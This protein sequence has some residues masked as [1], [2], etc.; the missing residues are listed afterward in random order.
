LPGFLNACERVYAAHQ[1]FAATLRP[2][3]HLTALGDRMNDNAKPALLFPGQGSQSVGMGQEL[4]DSFPTA[5]ATFDEADDALGFHLKHVIFE[6]PADTLQLTEYTQPA[7][8]AVSIAAFRVLSEQLPEL[9]PCFA[10]GHSLG[11]YAA[12]VAAGTI[13]FAEAIRT[14]RD[15]GRFMQQAVPAGQGAMAAILGLSAEVVNDLCAQACDEMTALPPLDAT[16]SESEESR[17][18][19]AHGVVSPANLNTPEQV[20]ISGSVAAV[21][22]AV[23]LCKAAGARKTIMLKVS[24]PFHCA[25]MQPAQEQLACALEAVTFNDPAYPVACNVDARLVTRAA[26][27]RDCLIR[28]VTGPVRWVECLDLLTGH[29]VTHLIEVGPGK[30]LSGLTRQILGKGIESPVSLNVEDRASLEKTLA[31]LN[32]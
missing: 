17:A 6:G 10:A 3:L 7:I 8:L 16:P 14:V 27:V 28:Q 24:A 11:E 15:R 25:L 18:E 32:S 23:E 20:V 4:Y 30:V 2:R 22:R 21:N 9:K 13:P 29:G 26:D 19:V 12:Y 5:K 31:A 1:A